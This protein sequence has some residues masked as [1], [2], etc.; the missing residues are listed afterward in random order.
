MPFVTVEVESGRLTLL[1][2]DEVMR[3]VIEK[4]CPI[5]LAFDDKLFKEIYH[6]PD[7]TRLN[8]YGSVRG[9]GLNE[10]ILWSNVEAIS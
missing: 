8:V 3:E 5:D 9:R 7:G 1:G 2:G 10:H 4:E 6:H